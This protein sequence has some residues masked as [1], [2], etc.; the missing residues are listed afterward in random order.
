MIIIAIYYIF[1]KIKNKN[2][3]SKVLF[4]TYIKYCKLKRINDLIFIIIK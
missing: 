2:A 4:T 1:T 3:L